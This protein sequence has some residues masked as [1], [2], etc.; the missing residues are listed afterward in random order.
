MPC[1][2]ELG[3]GSRAGRPAEDTSTTSTTLQGAVAAWSQHLAAAPSAELLS[4]QQRD[5]RAQRVPQ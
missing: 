3:S 2:P 1:C 4:S 5:C